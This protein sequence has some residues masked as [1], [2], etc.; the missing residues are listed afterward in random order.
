VGLRA[1]M[2]N[3]LGMKAMVLTIGMLAGCETAI[4]N[5]RGN[6]LLTGSEMDQITAG[7]VGAINK[8]EAHARGFTSQATASTSTLVASSSGTVAGVHFANAAGFNYVSSQLSASA[9][10]GQ[11]ATA[12][13]SN[14]IYVD[15]ENGVA[16]INAA[17]AAVSAGGST[18]RAEVGINFSG[19][20]TSRAD[21]ALGSVTAAA[22]CAPFAKAQI[23]LTGGA[24]GPYAR[25]L[26]SVSLSNTRGQIQMRTDI[27][28]ISSALPMID[29]GQTSGL[30]TPL[31]SPK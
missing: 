9:A 3:R 27:A 14:H 19:I 15:G 26:K 31:G 23:E 18:S 13:G 5:P 17:A 12:S 22:C 7:S 16:Q 6:R 28:V 29:P 24:G 20:R 21:L 4:P 10:I 8:A 1:S 11:T 2:G 25:E 30:L